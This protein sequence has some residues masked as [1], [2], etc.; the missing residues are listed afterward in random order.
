VF[1]ASNAV[2]LF[3]V[4]EHVQYVAGSVILGG[5]PCTAMVFVWSSLV[6]GHAAYT[7]IQ[8]AINDLVLLVL[9]VPTLY[10]LLDLTNVQIPYVTIILAVVIFVAVPFL[11]GAVIRWRLLHGC[12]AAE[13]AARLKAVDKLFSP[14]TM[15]GLLLTV[16]L[17]FIFQGP[18]IQ[19]RWVDILLI[20]VPLTLQTY[21]AFSVAFGA[22]YALNVEWRIAAPA[23]FISSSNFFELAIAIAMSSYGI[24][25]GAALATTVGVLT[26]VP[27]MLS[28]VYITL[29]LRPCFAKRDKARLKQQ[30]QQQQRQQSV[31][32]PHSTDDQEHSE[33]SSSAAIAC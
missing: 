14:V 20:A 29:A 11:L 28:L 13:G 15:V 22:L 16:L 24:G 30:Q 6:G 3:G 21:I 8:V 5:S 4:Y 9:Y 12:T 33:S 7:F 1:T 31:Q 18:T 10:L 19:Q 26:E 2:S 27:V 32:S 17:T 25:S 23:G